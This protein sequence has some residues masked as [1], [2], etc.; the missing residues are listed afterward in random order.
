MKLTRQRIIG[1][2]LVGMVLLGCAASREVRL[3]E[4]FGRQGNWDGAVFLY[5][6]AVQKDPKNLSLRQKLDE[7]KAKAAG[8]HYQ[9][10]RDLLKEKNHPQALEE[11]KGP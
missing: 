5:Q 10:G 3:G 4:Q 11:F 6:E 7:A 8:Q 9:K 1:V 2:S